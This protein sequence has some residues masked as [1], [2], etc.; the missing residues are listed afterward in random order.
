MTIY[1][2]CWTGG[3][4]PPQ[5]EGFTNQEAAIAQADDWRQQSNSENGDSI[6]VLRIYIHGD[7][8]EIEDVES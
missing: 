2:A 3:Y 8:V 7:D 5:F 4:E 6:D 1:L